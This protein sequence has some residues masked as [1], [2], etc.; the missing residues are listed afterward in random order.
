MQAMGLAIPVIREV[1]KMRYLWNNPMELV[2]PRLDAIL[3]PN[4]GTPFDQAVAA[5]SRQ[6]LVVKKAA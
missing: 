3:G 2:D 6:F 1:L 5:A 4:F